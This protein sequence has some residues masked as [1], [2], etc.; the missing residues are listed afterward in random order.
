MPYL[1]KAQKG[2]EI[3]RPLTIRITPTQRKALAE[4]EAQGYSIAAL[5]RV[6]LEKEIQRINERE[7]G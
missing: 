5:T 2:K 7:R 4:L 6:A 3:Y 1:T